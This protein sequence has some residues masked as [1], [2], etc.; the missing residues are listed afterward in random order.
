MADGEEFTSQRVV[1]A[2]GINP[3]ASKPAEFAAIP[4]ALASQYEQ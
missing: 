1:I 2:G 4:S 3:F